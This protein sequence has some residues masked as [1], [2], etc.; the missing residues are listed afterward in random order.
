MLIFF[1]SSAECQGRG[2]RQRP[3]CQVSHSS[4]RPKI[5][6]CFLHSIA[7]NLRCHIIWHPSKHILH[8]CHIHHIYHIN[9]Y[10]YHIYHNNF[11]HYSEQVHHS[12]QKNT[13]AWQ[14]V[15]RKSKSR[16]GAVQGHR[17]IALVS[18]GRGVV[19]AARASRA[20]NGGTAAAVWACTRACVVLCGHG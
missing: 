17:T 4:K 1:L 13:S 14:Q 16:R 9:H 5:F 19:G 7:T 18:G 2:T 11:I 10:I 15:H 12:F 3:L 6:F 20:S 8:I